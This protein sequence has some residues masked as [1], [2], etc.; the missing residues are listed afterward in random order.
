MPR[1]Q[2]V[3]LPRAHSR[4]RWAAVILLMLL[5]IGAL[6]YGFVSLLSSNPGYSEITANSTDGP[7]VSGDFVLLYNLGASGVAAS[8][9]SRRLTALYTD[10]AEKAYQLFTNDIGYQGV[11]NVYYLNR[12]VG[13]EVEVDAALYRAF[14]Q[15]AR[16]GDR[17][18]YLA[19]VFETYDG[20]FSCADDA[21]AAAFDPYQSETLRAYFAEVAAFAR[22]P[23]SVTLELLGEN[24]VCLRVSQ[25]Y[26]QFAE[27]EEIVRFIDFS[28]TRNA[29]I[30][31]YLADVLVENGY[32]LGTLSSY[33]GFMRN[34]DGESGAQYAFNVTSRQSGTVYPAAVL[35]YSGARSLVALRGYPLNSLDFQHYYTFADGRICTAYVDIRDGLCRNAIDE[36]TA[37]SE[38]LGCAEVLLRLIPLYIAQDW[39]EAAIDALADDGVFAVYA[40]GTRLRCTDPRLTLTDLYSGEDVQFSAEAVPTP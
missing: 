25:A 17:T 29:F 21:Q 2:R 15:I 12:H 28:W 16:A 26:Q 10:A 11:H 31:D 6:V 7:N 22:D 14:E 40:R 20:L 38:A 30:A 32:R 34:L 24:R 19:P 27:E 9:E 35:R 37:T 4:A 18:L 8:T 13:E 33:D 39:D 23:E 3:E 36:L 5:G 1:V